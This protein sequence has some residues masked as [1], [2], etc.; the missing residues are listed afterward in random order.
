MMLRVRQ[1]KGIER[2]AIVGKG[3]CIGLRRI[4]CSCKLIGHVDITRF[5]V[6]KIPQRNED[7]IAILRALEHQV[8]LCK[9]RYALGQNAIEYGSGKVTVLVEL[10]LRNLSRFTGRSRPRV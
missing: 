8:V 2:S 5:A 7:E 4:P 9:V 6:G 10:K 3:G 1:G